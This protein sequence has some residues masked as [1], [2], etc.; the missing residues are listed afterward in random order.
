MTFEAL[1]INEDIIGKLKKIGIKMTLSQ[2]R[3]RLVPGV[4]QWQ[5]CDDPRGA[6]QIDWQGVQ[7]SEG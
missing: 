6:R 7:A 1:K 2:G 5:G 4:H 3:G